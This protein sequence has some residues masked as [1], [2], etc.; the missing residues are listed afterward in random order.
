MFLI[1]QF[2]KKEI[3]VTAVKI[4]L[5]SELKISLIFIIKLTKKVAERNAL[6]NDS[7]HKVK[8]FIKTFIYYEIKCKNYDN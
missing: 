2:K 8:I 4:I 5:I 3:N 6:K 1:Y 7:K